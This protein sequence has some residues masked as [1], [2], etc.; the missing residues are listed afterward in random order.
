M[1]SVGAHDQGIAI[2]IGPGSHLRANISTGASPVL[3]NEWLP[4][5]PAQ[6]I[7]EIARRDIRPL[8]RL[9][10]HNDLDGL[11]RVGGASRQGC[12]CQAKAQHC[13]D[14]SL[15]VHGMSPFHYVL[16]LWMVASVL[17]R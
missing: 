15:L 1:G 14:C 5:G 11:F 2:G 9:I 6:I 8:A 7:G 17:L 16:T 4:Q 12:H 13:S 10:G 3:D